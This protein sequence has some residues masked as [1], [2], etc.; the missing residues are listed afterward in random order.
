MELTQ[1][2]TSVQQ[3]QH[4][5]QMLRKEANLEVSGATEDLHNDTLAL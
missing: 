4:Q 5:L 1:T 3:L 2:R